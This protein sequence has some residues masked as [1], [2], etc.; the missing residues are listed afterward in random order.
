MTSLEPGATRETR[1]RTGSSCHPLTPLTPPFPSTQPGKLTEVIEK[2]LA[3]EKTYRLVRPA[4]R[5]SPRA[6]PDPDRARRGRV[7]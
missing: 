5:S 6:F 4:P 7:R 2:M 1:D 3:H